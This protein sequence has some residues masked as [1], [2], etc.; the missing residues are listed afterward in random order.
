M[1]IN[2][3]SLSIPF[4][5]TISMTLP[6]QVNEPTKSV[7]K[8]G[9]I[10]AKPN[11]KGDWLNIFLLFMLYLMQ[12]TPIGLVPAISILLQSKQNVTYKEQALFGL[13]MWPL[14]L[15]LLWAPLVDSFY[16]Q[17]FGR[18]YYFQISSSPNMAKLI[19]LKCIRFFVL[20]MIFVVPTGVCFFY[21]ADSIDDLLPET[22]KPNIGLPNASSLLTVSP[23][24]VIGGT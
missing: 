19:T 2:L 7:V 24:A 12:C 17:K 1:I 5:K 14:S 4:Y 8:N 20:Q 6:K 9:L 15:K 13:V 11:L 16:V 23:Y 21:M 18:L 22:G 3:N 10:L